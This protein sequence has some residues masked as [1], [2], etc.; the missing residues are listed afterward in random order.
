MTSRATHSTCGASKLLYYRTKVSTVY[1]TTSISINTIVDTIKN[2]LGLH[3][4]LPNS[5][6]YGKSYFAYGIFG[7]I[8]EWILRGMKEEPETLSHLFFEQTQMI[9]NTIKLLNNSTGR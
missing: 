4:D 8:N 2:K 6:A 3:E 1:C 7:W 5:A 9:S